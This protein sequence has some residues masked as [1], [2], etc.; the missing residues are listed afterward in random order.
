MKVRL[1]RTG[2][3]VNVEH[4]IG[5][6]WGYVASNGNVYQEDDLMLIVEEPIDYWEGLKHQAAMYAMQGIITN[7]IGF[8]NIKARNADNLANEVAIAAIE[9]ANT[10]VEKL[11]SEKNDTTKPQD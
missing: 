8:E 10:L 3:V 9:F 7:P 4:N 5:Y 6:P 11:K 1:K 2:E